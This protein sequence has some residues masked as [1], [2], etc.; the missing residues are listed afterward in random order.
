[1][2][3]PGL[4][5]ADANIRSGKYEIMHNSAAQRKKLL[6]APLLV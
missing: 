3:L 1:M 6:T 5:N 2:V 4:W